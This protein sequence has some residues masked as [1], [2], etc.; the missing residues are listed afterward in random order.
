MKKLILVVFIIAF[1]PVLASAQAH[2]PV[3]AWEDDGGVW[4]TA[5]DGRCYSS[6][7]VDPDSN[8]CN[9]DFVIDV[10]IHASIAQWVKFTLDGRRW[11]WFVR[12]PGYY[13]A[14]CIAATLWSN[15]DV[16]VQYRNFGPLIAEDQEK[17]V[18]DTIY[19][20]YAVDAVGWN[21]PPL[22]SDPAWVPAAGLNEK[23]EWDTVPDSRELHLFGA[24]FKL[25]NYIWV[26]SCNSACEYHDQADITLY[27]KCQKDWIDRETG[28]YIPDNFWDDDGT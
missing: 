23:E 8:S 28:D 25:W 21:V 11:D 7:P 13:A 3:A 18:L 2:T 9:K 22:R 27:L 26:Q 1:L 6:Y 19:I 17:A 5:V 15:Q 10:N 24:K 4:V 14:D 16:E 20:W 12:K